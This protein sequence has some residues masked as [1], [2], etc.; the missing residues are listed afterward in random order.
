LLDLQGITEGSEFVQL[1]DDYDDEDE[2][3]IKRRRSVQPN[4]PNHYGEI[5]GIL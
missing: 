4:R 5:E 2:E 1:E 3:E